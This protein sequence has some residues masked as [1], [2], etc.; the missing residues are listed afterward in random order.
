MPQLARMTANS[1]ED[2][3]LR[4]PY[5]AK[6][7]KMLEPSSRT[8]GS[9]RSSRGGMARAG[10]SGATVCG[11]NAHRGIARPSHDFHPGTGSLHKA[12][13]EP[14]DSFNPLEQACV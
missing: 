8:M 14:R 4:C 10:S 9:R 11:L 6:V 7:M 3:Y 13:A 1:G 12:E 5:Q 2:L